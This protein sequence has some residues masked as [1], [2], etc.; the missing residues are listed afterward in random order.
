MMIDLDDD[1]NAME[2]EDPLSD[3]VISLPKQSQAT[4]VGLVHLVFMI[5]QSSLSTALLERKALEDDGI[6]TSG[7]YLQV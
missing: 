3:D 2:E 5:L 7:R 4:Q 1:L 6:K